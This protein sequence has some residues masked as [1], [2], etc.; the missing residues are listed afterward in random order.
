VNQWEWDLLENKTPVDAVE[1]LGVQV[2]RGDRIRLRPRAGG[3]IF[4]LALTDKIALVESIE[5][6]YEGKLHLGVVLEDDPGRDIGLM[7][8][9]RHRFFFA[10]DEVEPAA[11]TARTLETEA[12][13]L[14]IAGVGNIFRADD[15]FGVEVAT[16]LSKQ[17]FPSGVRVINFGV[18]GFDLAYALM[19]G[20]GTTILVD[21]YPGEGPPGSLFVL[22]PDL[23]NADTAATQQG[24]VE[25]HA[26]NTVN[27]L[28]LATNVGGQLKRVLVVGC[29]QA[30]LGPE[31]GQMGLSEPV[32]AAVDQAVK[33]ID[34]LVTQL[35]ADEGPAKA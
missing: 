10:P 22:E 12:K 17:V 9:P 1:I 2:R 24:F 13:R 25:P 35:L 18:R 30:T 23:K 3:D 21:A 14:L 29:V 11:E 27:V 34:S 15:G 6:D 4:D 19:E 7:R 8:Q 20:Y 33:L 5:Q 31:E 28:R 26:M 16:R 32:A